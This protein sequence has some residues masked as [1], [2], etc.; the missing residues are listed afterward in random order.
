VPSESR[1]RLAQPLQLVDCLL[2]LWAGWSRNPLLHLGYGRSMSAKL[3]E[4]HEKGIEPEHYAWLQKELSCPDGVLLIDRLV[5]RLDR[6]LHAAICVQYF[7]YA[8]IEMKARDCHMSVPTYR[9]NLDRALWS[10]L[11][12][13]Q[14]LEIELDVD[15]HIKTA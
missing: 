8:P 10:L 6:P 9:R 11:H 12:L 13:I 2:D 14:V 1:R 15:A 7:T 4:W 5:A 3:I